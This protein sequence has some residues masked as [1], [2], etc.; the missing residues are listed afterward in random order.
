MFQVAS[1]SQNERL[2]LWCKYK[3]LT[4][5]HFSIHRYICINRHILRSMHTRILLCQY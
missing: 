2:E 3:F 1:K 5:V 4:H